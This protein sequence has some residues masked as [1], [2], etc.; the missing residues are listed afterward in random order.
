MPHLLVIH[1]A[2]SVL[3]MCPYFIVFLTVG[4]FLTNFRHAF[5]PSSA[6]T[7][8]QIG[9][10][11]AS[12]DKPVIVPTLFEQ[13]IYNPVPSESQQV[14]SYCHFQKKTDVLTGRSSRIF[15]PER[16]AW[17]RSHAPWISC[18]RSTTY[19][20]IAT[21]ISPEAAA[22]RRRRGEHDGPTN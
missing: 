9:S 18:T 8:D 17:R 12:A 10:D 5:T 11:F 1:P 14:S 16:V 4:R 20:F 2:R 13:T 3:M 19:Y 22:S 15:I 7:T 6:S 21:A